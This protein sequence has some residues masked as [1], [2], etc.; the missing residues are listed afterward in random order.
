M[1]ARRSASRFHRAA[2][3][4]NPATTAIKLRTSFT[5]QKNSLPRLRFGAQYQFRARAVD[6]AGNSFAPDATLDEI[7]NLP[8]QPISY[9]RHEPVVAP[10]IVLRQALDPIATPGE[11]GNRIVI[12]SNFNT[13][14]AAVSERHIAPPKTTE[15]MAETHGMLDTPAGP[16]DKSL[17]EMLVAKDRTFPT[18]PAD[19]SQPVP[20]PGT[21]LPLPYLPDPFAV[22]AAFATLPGMPAGSVWPQPFT[23]TWPETRPF[24]LVLDE[25]SSPP[26]VHRKRNRAC[27]AR[28]S[29]QGRGRD[30]RHELLS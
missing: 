20:F 28:A 24:R 9:L 25:G 29:S 16:P 19:P 21:Q 23:G 1:P 13:H 30:G 18:N 12:R 14:I 8:P 17:Y 22:G 26:Q 3:A 15:V 5:A 6:L 4:S 10:A 7:Y 27:A 2:D 11:S